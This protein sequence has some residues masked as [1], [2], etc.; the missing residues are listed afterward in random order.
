M[1]EPGELTIRTISSLAEVD[2]SAWDALSTDEDSPFVKH[3]WLISLE[4]AGCLGLEHGWIS[5]H[6]TVWR[7]DRLV[8]ACPAYLKL[9]SEGEFVFDHGWANAADRIGVEYY[10]KLIVAVPFTPATGGRLL[11]RAD[12]RRDLLA[13]LLAGAI[14]TVADKLELSSAHVLFALERDVEVLEK[15]GYSMRFGVQNHWQNRGYKTYDDFLATFNSKRRHQLKRERREVIQ[16]GIET[17][18]HR[19]ETLTDDALDAM[20]VF[21]LSSVER[22]KPWTRQ[23]V[24]RKFFGLIRDR[25]PNTLEVVIAREKGQPIAGA[26]NVLGTNGVL[27]GRYWGATE[28]RPFLHFHVCYY[29]SID[30]CIARGLST[31]EPGAGGSH[32]VPRGFLP[33]ITRSAHYIANLRFRGM[34]DRFLE[35]EREA[36]LKHVQG[37][38]GD[39]E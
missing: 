1:N 15:A 23:Y 21:Y 7:G 16:S 4:D 14:R 9:N 6:I 36:V 20:N 11:V 8:A 39:P 13:P 5:Q 12:E 10:P 37:D 34:I 32:K 18:T 29:H 19:G 26:L 24:N 28:E 22:F 31:F 27:Y 3:A 33:S 35:A 38:E 25:M 2:A 30:E 17:T